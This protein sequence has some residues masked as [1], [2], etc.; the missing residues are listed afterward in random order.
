LL[1]IVNYT[2]NYKHENSVYII[3]ELPAVAFVG[4]RQI[5][6][7]ERATNIELTLI[8]VKKYKDFEIRSYE[9]TLFTSVTMSGK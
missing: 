4:V 6:S 2:Q 5:S 9:T 8:V 7:Y 3:L 1:F